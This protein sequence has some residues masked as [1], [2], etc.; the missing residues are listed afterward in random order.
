MTGLKYIITLTQIATKTEPKTE[1]FRPTDESTREPP[2]YSKWGVPSDIQNPYTVLSHQIL[3]FLYPSNQA[4]DPHLT[5]MH[6]HFSPDNMKDF[7]DKYTHFHV[8]TPLL[9]LPTFRIM[10]VGN[11]LLAIMCCIGACYSDRIGSSHVRDMMDSTW[12]AF[13]RESR[14]MNST[15]SASQAMA[16][17]QNDIEEL[18]AFVLMIIVHLW[19]GTPQQ[20]ERARQMFPLLVSRARQFGLLQVAGGSHRFNPMQW[21]SWVDKERRIRLMYGIYL[22]DTAMGLYFN[23]PAQIDAFELRNPLPCDDAAWEAESPWRCA[24][25]LGHHGP[26]DAYKTNPYG[27]RRA[28]QPEVDQAL[29]ALLDNSQEIQP[30]STNLYGKFVLIHALIAII[31]QAQ[32]EGRLTPVKASKSPL[33]GDWLQSWNPNNGSA[34]P[35]KGVS[36]N[37]DAQS[38]TALSF[39][40]EKFKA[41][42]DVDMENQFPPVSLGAN[43][44][45]R[46]GFSRDGVHF[47]WLAKYLLKFTTSEELQLEP[48]ARFVQVIQYLKGVRMWV[49]NDGLARGEELGSIGEIDDQFGYADL[50]LDMAQLFKP[51]PHVVEDAGTTSVKTELGST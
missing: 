36:E 45:Q 48:D 41:N 7:V 12:S 50:T 35:V 11:G 3:N 37:I 38:L 10:D 46:H 17:S 8:H 24:E 2:T 40:L 27:T 31:Q 39:A 29:K 6:L 18:Q 16:A 19:N 49:M 14:M 13:H 44:P 28:Q 26:E 23:I 21:E 51:L 5:G 1:P 34:T 15:L 32:R 4:L 43:N 9:H 30:G 33:T 47:F 25:A 22:G 42:W 20:R